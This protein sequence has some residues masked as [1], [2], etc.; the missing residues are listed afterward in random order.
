M[1]AVV[2]GRAMGEESMETLYRLQSTMARLDDRDRLAS[3]VLSLNRRKGV[4][5]WL[6]CEL[7][8]DLHWMTGS[9]EHHSLAIQAMWYRV[10]HALE[11]WF[12]DSRK[13]KHR[14]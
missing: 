6:A 9:S 14:R 10:G 1:Q 3:S 12:D 11:A 2:A 7:I 13:R 5:A 4:M 8:R